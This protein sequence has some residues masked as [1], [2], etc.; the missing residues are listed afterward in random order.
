MSL[1][2]TG[3]PPGWTIRPGYA[4]LLRHNQD[5]Q[6]CL[7]TERRIELGTVS[8]N[9]TGYVPPDFHI[10]VDMLSSYVCLRVIR[11]SVCLLIKKSEELT[12]Y[13]S[14]IPLQWTQT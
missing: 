2:G 13:F 8:F 11:R 4:C 10:H 6:V 7:R 5:N 9:P 12:A 3:H 14:P 1:G